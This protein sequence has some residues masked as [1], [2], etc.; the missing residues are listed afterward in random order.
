MKNLKYISMVLLGGIMYGTMSSLVKLAYQRGFN[1]AELS[2]WQAF[3]AVLLLGLCALLLRKTE[4]GNIQNKDVLP[5]ILIGCAIGLTNFLYYESVQYIS[6]SLAIVILMQFTWLG[7]LLEWIV[8]K[9][10]ASRLAMLTVF[11]ILIGTIMAGGVLEMTGWTF[12]AK[13]TLLALSA[14][15]TYAVYIIANGRC[16]KTVRWQSKSMT[17]MVGSSTC[18]FLINSQTILSGDYLCSE[19]AGWAVV[20]AIIGTTVPTA[21]FAAGI[22]KIGAGIS[23]I[24]MTVE[25][26]VAVLCAR[27]ILHERISP[28]QSAGIIIMLA[29]ISAMN[30]YKVFKSK[31][32]IMFYISEIKDAAPAAFRTE[33]QKSVYETFEKLN[34]PF[35]RV[36]T[37][38]AVTMDD[39][40]AINDKLDMKMVKTLF[41]C[42]RQQTDFYLFVTR[43]DKPFRSKD[44]SHA[45]DI[46]RV[47]F[48]PAELLLDM[49]QT[50][51][52]ATTVLSM[53][54]D[55]ENRVKVVLDSEVVREE[56]YG[57]SDGTT[58]GY[59]KIR[60]TD[61]VHRFLDYTN[62]KPM[63]VSI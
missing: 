59:L 41:L 33:L 20:L 56:W 58:T 17:I 31:S 21:L 35:E 13:G 52:G 27:I 26:P 32:K 62:H 16:G 48:A 38:E 24:L 55:T 19:F 61:I 1:A 45:L 2:F 25:L 23:S 9:R 53:L 40:V 30:Y 8:F 57:C 44:F 5:L 46:A 3:L 11:F 63:I 29:S 10:K 7:L 39:C 49:L 51:V 4:K 43:G 22:S 12:S 15:L 34:I 14:S 36:D 6:A 60:T 42:N 18:I 50:P 54:V 28:L 47:S 37:D